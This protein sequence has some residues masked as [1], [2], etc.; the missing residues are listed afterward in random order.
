MR[1]S[2]QKAIRELLIDNEDGLTVRQI[3]EQMGVDHHSIRRAIQTTYGLYIDRWTKP[4]GS[5]LT[6][7]Y[8][9]V[10]VPANTPKPD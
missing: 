7:V 2:R 10:H 3:S 4:K 9:C 8:M 6:A 1:F 5:P